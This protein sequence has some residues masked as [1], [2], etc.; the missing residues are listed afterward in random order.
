[1]GHE[2]DN[3]LNSQAAATESSSTGVT[4]I[5]KEESIQVL[6]LRLLVLLAIFLA[7]VAVSISVYFL[8]ANS[9]KD[10]FEQQFEGASSKILSSFEEIVDRKVSQF[11]CVC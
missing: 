10:E 9:E 11:L 4:A 1:M 3:T 5:G 2:C 7:A 8:T 6:R